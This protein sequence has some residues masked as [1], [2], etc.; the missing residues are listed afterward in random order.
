MLAASAYPAL[1]LNADFTPYALWTWQDAIRAVFRGVAYPVAEY[2]ASVAS[3]S[4]RFQLPSV[5][6]L[7]R[8]VDLDRP[9]AFT[10]RN[11]FLAYGMRCV[12]CGGH[13]KSEDLTF[14]HVVPRSRGGNLRGFANVAPACLPCNNRK[15]NKTLRE[16][17]M[18]LQ[19]PLYHPTERMIVE[20]RLR[21]AV[22]DIPHESWNDF[23]GRLYWDVPLD[24]TS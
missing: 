18:H 12:L 14:E 6:A 20:A 15:G 13:F 4:T 19:M 17:G 8:F 5:I 22:D 24:E 3:P 9:A 1:A 10:R 7:N 16:A 21:L 2:N 11:V 23:L